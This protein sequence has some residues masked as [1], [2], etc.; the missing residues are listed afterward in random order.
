MH[1]A[2]RASK[3][4]ETG[5]RPP[6]ALPSRD[7][8]HWEIP[9]TSAHHCWPLTQAIIFLLPWSSCP[10]HQPCP[11]TH[12]PQL[13]APWFDATGRTSLNPNLLSICPALS[14]PSAPHHPL[15][16]GMRPAWSTAP[17]SGQTRPSYTSA[18]N[19]WLQLLC[20]RAEF[21]SSGSCVLPHA[22]MQGSGNNDRGVPGTVGSQLGSASTHFSPGWFSPRPP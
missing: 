13:S 14:C 11:I 7:W 17:T 5:Y 20:P 15:K 8:V 6:P 16:A 10:R 9:A 4:S 19:Q 12:T 1:R 22:V 21:G 2:Q 3:H 18:P